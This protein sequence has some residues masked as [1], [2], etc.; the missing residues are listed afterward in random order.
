MPNQNS[1]TREL[2]YSMTAPRY[3]EIPSFMRSL[4]DRN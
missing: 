2:P 4:T 1:D 3:T